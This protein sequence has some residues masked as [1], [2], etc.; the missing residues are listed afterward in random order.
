MAQMGKM[1]G[2]LTEGNPLSC[3]V[4]YLIPLILGNLF[5]QFYSIADSIIVGRMIS[6]DALAAVGSTA[7]LTGLFVMVALGTGVGCSVVIAQL[8]G[9]GQLEKLKS[10][11]STELISVFSLSVCLSLVGLLTSGVLL[12]WLNTPANIYQDAKTYLDIYF[13]GFF[14][15][16]LYNAFTSVFN[17]LGDSQKPL[18]FL[19]F[20]SALN[21]ALDIV[22]IGPMSM[23]VAG[24]AWATLIAQAVSAIL[25]F[26]VLIGKLSK[27]KTG[28]YARFDRSLLKTMVKVA[29][30]SILQQSV[31]SIGSVLIQG[32]I[33]PFGSVFLAGYTAGARID[34]IAIVP[35]VN[36]GNAV[37]TFVAQ[38]MGARK[39]ERAKQGCRIGIGMAVLLSFVIGVA[40]H[41]FGENVIGLFMD[42]AEAADSIAIGTQYLSIV[43]KCYLIM[44]LMKIFAGVLRGSGDMKC[45]VYCTMISLAVRLVLTYMFAEATQ[46]MIIAWAIVAGWAA[47]ALV[48]Y[49]RYRQGGWQK[50]DLVGN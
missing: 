22:F 11:I 34:G 28:A 13:Y 41:F 21:I 33:N 14:F 2:N 9:A 19:I 1:K 27:I 5:Q 44:G 29:V 48:A 18:I 12:T 25:S 16:F 47:G 23:G 46:G 4:K 26:A 20:S 7:T 30:P 17:A 24:A 50:I 31:V 42:S 39:M 6:A 40:L 8:F 15:L 43:S 49:I 38:N 10:A 3:M 45:F 36:C 35:L 32:C 37:S